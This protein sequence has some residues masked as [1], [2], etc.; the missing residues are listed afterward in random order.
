MPKQQQSRLDTWLQNLLLQSPDPKTFTRELLRVLLPRW[1]ALHPGRKQPGPRSLPKFDVSEATANRDSPKLLCAVREDANRPPAFAPRRRARRAPPARGICVYKTQWN[2]V[3]FG[4]WL[5]DGL[6]AS[7]AQRCEPACP[8][9]YVR[10]ATV[11]ERRGL[12]P[13]AGTWRVSESRVGPALP[14]R[15]AVPQG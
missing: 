14:A 7:R 2:A 6:P 3:S 15:D 10:H 1:R 13:G 8:P 9:V 5:Y 12:A 11:R 4:P